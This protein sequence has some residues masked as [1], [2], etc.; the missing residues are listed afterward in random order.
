MKKY[1]LF[2][3]ALVLILF[4]TTAQTPYFTWVGGFDQVAGE[5]YIFQEP[6]ARKGAVSW[7][8]NSEVNLNH[9][10]LWLYG[11]FGFDGNGEEGNLSDLWYYNTLSK[12]WTW[13][14]GSHLKNEE[15][16]SGTKGI[17]DPLNHPGNRV[18]SVSWTDTDGNLWLFG[19]GRQPSGY[20]FN[21]LWKFNTVSNEWTWISGSVNFGQ[22]QSVIGTQG[23]G[24]TANTPGARFGSTSWTDTDGNLWLFGGYGYVESLGGEVLQSDLWKFEISTGEWTYYGEDLLPRRIDAQSWVDGN[25]DLWL[26]GGLGYNAA[27]T[28]FSHLND[29]WKYTPGSDTWILIDVGG[30]DELG[31]YGSKG[32]ANLS[33]YP[34]SRYRSVGWTDDAD[35]LWMSGGFGYDKAT[36]DP[37]N[38]G[39]IWKY[40]IIDNQWTWMN[41]GDLVNQSALYGEKQVEAANN[42]PTAQ[43][44]A[45]G[46]QVGSGKFWLFGGAVSGGKKNDL[47]SYNVNTNEWAWQAGSQETDQPGIFPIPGYSSS[48]LN[49]PAFRNAAS[50]V[51]D[52]DGNFWLFGGWYNQF[53]NPYGE[54]NDLWRYT[55]A[56]KEW[57]YMGGDLGLNA[58]GNYG[59]KGASSLSNMPS[60][61]ELSGLTVDQNGNLW[62]FGG[63]DSNFEELNDLWKY[64]ISTGIWT[65]VS[66]GSIANE[67]AVYGQMGVA[68]LN[69]VPGATGGHTLNF[70]GTDNLILF[71]GSG[72]E[73]WQ[74]SI[75]SGQWTW[76]KGQGE[77]ASFGTKGVESPDNIPGAKN[78]HSSWL[79][80]DQLWVFGGTTSTNY[81]EGQNDLWKF[82]FNTGMWSWQSGTNQLNQ[83]GAY[84]TQNI[85]S[86]SNRPGCRNG[87]NSWLD[88]AGNLWLSGGYGYDKNGSINYLNDYWKYDVQT[89]VWTW[90]AGGDL[91]NQ[92]ATYGDQGISSRDNISGGRW[93]G[94]SASDEEGNFWSFGGTMYDSQTDVTGEVNQLWKISF[95]PKTAI[96]S[97]SSNVSSTGFTVSWEAI[98]APYGADSYELDV[99][100]DNTFSAIVNGY[101]ALTVNATS[102]AVTGLNPNT[103]YYVR[104]RAI[105]VVGS[106]DYSNVISLLTSIAS[107]VATAA[108]SVSQT[109]MTVNWNQVTGA[110]KYYV[111]VSF[112]QN[113]S[114]PISGYDGSV[115]VTAPL[116]SLGV[117]GLSSGT[118]YYYG[119]IAENAAGQ[120]EISNKISVLTIPATPVA[121]N[122][123]TNDITSTTFKAGWNLISGADIY[124]L[125][126]S[127]DD[128]STFLSGY[129]GKVI[130]GNTT[131]EILTGLTTSTAYK[132][133]LRSSNATGISGNSNVVSVLT[134]APPIPL[135][136]SAVSDDPTQ[137]GGTNQTISFSASGGS[138]P[139]TVQIRYKGLLASS[140]ETGTPAE[141]SPGPYTF[142]ITSGMLDELGLEYIVEI[143]DASS[144]TDSEMGTIY[145]SFSDGQSPAI[146]FAKFGGTDATWNIFSIPY[147]LNNQS[148]SSVFADL[149]QSRHEFDWRIVRYRNTTNDYINFN[150]GQNKIGEAYWF[151]SKENVTIKTGG[152][153]IITDLPKTITLL[154]GW[155][156]IGNPYPVAINWTDVLAD[157]QN[158]TVTGVDELQQFNGITQNT[159][160]ALA[161]FGGGFVFAESQVSVKI[162]PRVASSARIDNVRNEI[163]NGGWLVALSLSD[164]EEQFKVGGFGMHPEASSSKDR[165]DEMAV[166]RFFSY[167]DLFTEHD[168]FYSRFAKD[169]V[170]T[171]SVHKWEFTLS[172]NVIKGP[173]LLTWDND[174]IRQSSA[175]LY[176]L[177][178]KSGR[179]LDMK[180]TD[181]AHVNLASGDF[182]FEVVFSVTGDEFIPDELILGSAYPNPARNRVTIPVFLPKWVQGKRV[183]LVIYDMNGKEVKSIA[184][185]IFAPGAYEFTWEIASGDKL[186][187]GLYI[188]KLRFENEIYPAI[189]N[190]IILR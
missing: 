24:S 11:G 156:L 8:V 68:D 124:S 103:T 133:R 186:G 182:Q 37:G 93:L 187:A 41:G 159:N 115:S 97:G 166:P 5:T 51:A 137:A 67:P 119:V 56:S 147:N 82:N 28:G 27:N 15:A 81:T 143:T 66:G 136:L 128:F 131:E 80:G 145:R 155:N 135:A 127:E 62:L 149:D 32:I 106:S 185:G 140:Y 153:Q 14:R 99:A 36:P 88:L 33:N 10:K 58:P 142:L 168:Y 121:V 189:E 177:D 92:L 19:G 139:Y 158:S 138:A 179:V 43:S 38:L 174:D 122:P 22:Q 89:S 18:S 46:W 63:L 86:Q 126:V 164:G 148:L 55:I 75:S 170:P 85:G 172:S 141:A 49:I 129:N 84:G 48:S 150:T 169:V 77:V 183:E 65:W 53:G 47:W 6:G 12:D 178:R 13:V 73:L 95:A 108:T 61:R 114:N 120:S 21:D 87:S 160:N 26:F 71:G 72:N 152:G 94:A 74:Y 112:N 188:S 151:N 70:D 109:G 69:N 111:I 123:A 50:M 171:S 54:M 146:P 162:D 83:P 144:N 2:Y 117:T 165:F 102:Y 44:H 180:T 52:L 64:E 90:V 91:I 107:P 161:V 30:D 42:T 4:E 39:D 134:A 154:A 3:A 60:A 105:N 16:N 76:V 34:G 96:V 57:A 45:L 116:S 104:I 157:P 17:S 1:I 190:K 181:A 25:N 173:V 101:A 184:K 9:G 40:S 20:H 176:L 110:D 130:P 59:T 23:I 132:Y 7:G 35:N 118:Q 98:N 79:N 125:D 167:T 31:N 175:S 163:E 78:L 29:L 100:T 113:L